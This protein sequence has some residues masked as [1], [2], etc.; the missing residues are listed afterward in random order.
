MNSAKQGSSITHPPPHPT[1]RPCLCACCNL[2]LTSVLDGDEWSVVSSSASLDASDTRKASYLCRVQNYN[3]LVV[4]LVSKEL[5]GLRHPGF[6]NKLKFINKLVTVWSETFKLPY[7]EMLK[8]FSV[9]N[10]RKV[11]LHTVFIKPNVTELSS[12]HSFNNCSY[13]GITLP[14]TIYPPALVF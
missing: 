10:A 1:L 11:K 2:L 7:F 12:S 9:L 3:F 13:S 8:V 4:Q 14:W 5:Y 6:K